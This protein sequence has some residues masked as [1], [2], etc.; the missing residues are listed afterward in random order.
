MGTVIVALVLVAVV[1]LIIWSMVKDK[2]KGKSTCGGN[3]AH[4][5]ANCCH[6]D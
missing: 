4:C 5:S 3:C 2:K 6:K 1:G